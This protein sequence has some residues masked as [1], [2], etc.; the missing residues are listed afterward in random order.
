MKRPHLH[1]E[2]A[3]GQLKAVVRKSA[4]ELLTTADIMQFI[5]GLEFWD[6]RIVQPAALENVN[7]AVIKLMAQQAALDEAMSALIFDLKT[8][9]HAL[10]VEKIL[11]AFADFTSRMQTA[12]QPTER[13]TMQ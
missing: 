2:S 11:A 13:E 3:I 8:G 5:E 4:A 6:A 10:K 1:T 7:Q 12:P 9:A